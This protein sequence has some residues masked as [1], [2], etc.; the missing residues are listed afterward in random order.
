M[1]RFL[2]VLLIPVM[3]L[4]I[5]G[6]GKSLETGDEVPYILQGTWVDN[7]NGP[8]SNAGATIWNNPSFV[9]GANEMTIFLPKAGATGPLFISGD[10]I[11]LAFA[12][13]YT[14]AKGTVENFEKVVAEAILADGVYEFTIKITRILDGVEW[15]TFKFGL[16]LNAF[17]EPVLT[18]IDTIKI[19]QSVV[20]YYEFNEL[21]AEEAEFELAFTP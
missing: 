14:G 1:K 12:A 19:D 21:L 2:L 18:V 15:G 20:P 10:F 8:N 7:G 13:V 6:C 5:M 11:Q 9:F 3:V 4:G 16:S 17:D